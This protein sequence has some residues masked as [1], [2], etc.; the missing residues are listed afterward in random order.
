MI[1]AEQ[2]R[3]GGKIASATLLTG[4]ALVGLFPEHARAGSYEIDVMLAGTSEKSKAVSGYRGTPFT[5]TVDEDRLA[6]YAISSQE[7][8]D[9]PCLIWIGTE[10]VNDSARTAGKFRNLCDGDPS[11]RPMRAEYRDDMYHGPRVFVTGIRV[12]TNNKE[13][14]V[15]GF[16]LRGKQIEDDGGLAALPVS[17]RPTRLASGGSNRI[18]RSDHVND[19]EHPAD[20][21]NHCK[22]WHAWA[23]CPHPHQVATG[24]IGHFEAGKEPRSL[25]G[26]E[27]QCRLVAQSYVSARPK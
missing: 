17:P 9:N 10:D 2:G 4:L 26:I 16:Q 6:I 22:E 11:S 25:T 23:D 7:Q 14:R 8:R 24:L 18:K 20:Y 21:R 13:T 5:V 27:L 15:K 19:P 12:C 3:T 1:R